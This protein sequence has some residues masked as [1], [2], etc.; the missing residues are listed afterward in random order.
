MPVAQVD[1]VARDT[2]A[3]DEDRRPLV[4]ELL[5]LRRQIAG[6]R[7]QQVDSERLV[8]FGADGPD[9]VDHLT[10]RHRRGAEAA[11]PTGLGH[12]G[13]E[14][15][16]GDAAHTGEHHRVL[17]TEDVGEARAHERDPTLEWRGGRRAGWALPAS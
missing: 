8:R 1:H 5:H 9:L 12:R 3:G 4:D 13:N 11:E 14:L 16:V 15:A 7:R 17:D 10:G 6:H 2:Q